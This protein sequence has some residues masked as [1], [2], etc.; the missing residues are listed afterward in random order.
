[1]L[2]QIEQVLCFA[3]V[4]RQGSITAAADYLGCSKAHVSR[5]LAELEKY[6]STQ[7]MLRTTRRIHLTDAGKQMLSQAQALLKQSESCLRQAQ[8]LNQQLSGKFCITAP[9]SISTHLITPLIP[10]LQQQFPEIDFQVTSTNQTVDLSDGEVD[11][12]IRTGSVIDESLVARSLGQVH[13]VFLARPD[14]ANQIA[15][16]L[17]DIIQTELL[18]HPGSLK[19]GKLVLHSSSETFEVEP[20]KAMQINEFTMMISLLR[21]TDY[22]ALLPDYCQHHSLSSEK[23]VPVL[24]QI[25][26][27]TWPVYLVYPFQSPMPIKLRQVSDFIFNALKSMLAKTASS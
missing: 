24:P 25:R 9:V 17:D 11:L 23:L 19:Q 8:Q 15:P 7:L 13:E 12:A 2:C 26:G 27:D 6:T 4:C 1:M 18:V 3:V 5:K 16:G 10:R 20:H 22:V 14:V 21:Q